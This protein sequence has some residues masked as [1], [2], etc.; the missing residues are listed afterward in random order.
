MK[1]FYRRKFG[2]SKERIFHDFS[3][4]QT[5]AVVGEAHL[6]ASEAEGSASCL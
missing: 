1:D 4:H 6:K 2:K 3:F 5:R